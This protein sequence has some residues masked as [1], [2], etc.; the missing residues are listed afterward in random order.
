[1]GTNGAWSSQVVTAN[2]VIIS[3]PD[4]F[5]LVYQGAAAPGNLKDSVTPMAGTD[6]EGNNYQSDI[7]AYELGGNGYAQLSAGGAK[8]VDNAGNAWTI[9]AVEPGGVPYL[10]IEGNPFV[11]V[12][13]MSQA[14]LLVASQP[15]SPGTP[16]TWHA[17][18]L[19][20]GWSAVAG[21]PVPSYRLLPDGTVEVCGS[22]THASFSSTIPF[23]SSA[24][25]TGYV[26]ATNQTVGASVTGDGSLQVLSTGAVNALTNGGA[27]TTV[28]FNGHY[29]VNL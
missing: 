14:G 11:G 4:D 22:A 13:L 8:F 5:L 2:Q 28:R 12:L 15:G 25:P 6:D 20:S 26:P 27:T 24:M 23:T 17:F 1:V 3:G 9:T 16:E 10:A 18:P 19:A 7:T 21:E 29:P